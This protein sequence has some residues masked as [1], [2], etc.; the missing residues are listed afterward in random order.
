MSPSQHGAPG[1]APAP[2][3]GVQVTGVL[4]LLC[5]VG[6]LLVSIFIA[7]PSNVLNTKAG[8]SRWRAALAIVL[9]QN[10]EFFTKPPSDPELVPYLVHDDGTV[11]YA[12]LLPNSRPEN[13]FGLSRSQRAQGPEL[14]AMAN[15]VPPDSWTTCTSE[16]DCLTLA[17]R[18]DPVVVRNDSPVAT[19]CGPAVLLTTRPVTWGYRELYEGWRVDE[20]A[21][22]VDA[23]C[24][25]S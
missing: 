10:W 14:A 23:H 7:L 9:P 6:P 22:H 24:S 15:Q 5:L 8:P 20:G 16:T 11:H 12:S 13:L 25:E 3:R 18:A 17:R 4:A 21:A 2:A 1:Q 19:V